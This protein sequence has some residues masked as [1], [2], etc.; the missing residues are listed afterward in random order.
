MSV[1]S[2]PSGH[3]PKT[4]TP[5][6]ALE[7]PGHRA[8]LCGDWPSNSHKNRNVPDLETRPKERFVSDHL[9]AG[10]SGKPSLRILFCCMTVAVTGLQGFHLFRAPS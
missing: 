9:P 10:C 8:I 6:R 4:K 7:I 5:D 1:P 2:E 3:T